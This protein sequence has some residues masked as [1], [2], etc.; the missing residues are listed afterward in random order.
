MLSTSPELGNNTAPAR[1]QQPD[2]HFLHRNLHVPED[3][4]LILSSKHFLDTFCPLV[5][6]SEAAHSAC[7]LLPL[8]FPAQIKAPPS[9]PEESPLRS[10]VM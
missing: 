8:V 3:D 10:S 7:R 4:S 9:I 2:Y 6:A 5:P 1:K